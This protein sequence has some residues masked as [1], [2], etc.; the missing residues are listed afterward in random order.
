MSQSQVNDVNTNQNMEDEVEIDLV[1]LLYYFR[2]KLLF[3][4]L[5]FIIGVLVS[6]VITYCFITPKYKATSKLYMVS[7]STDSI[8]N[9]ADLNLGTSLSEDYAELIKTR[10]VI[11]SVIEDL[12]LS[13]TYEDLLEMLSVGTVSKTRILTI[14]TTSTIPEEAKDISNALV[15]KAITYLPS[16]METAE[17]NIAEQA[18]LPTMK[19]SPSYAKNMAIGSIGCLVLCL[20]ILTVLYMR[21]DTMKTAEDIE[22]VFG[23][24]PLTVIPEG[25]IGQ[26]KEKKQRVKANTRRKNRKSRE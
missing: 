6:G 16:V 14:T 22:K 11:E 15:S 26:D 8:V 7:A 5:S 13:Y 23:V 21:D 19:S 10:P 4:L 24:M 2:S 1:E 12:N 17:P 3:I 18:I 25:N 20:L 9:L